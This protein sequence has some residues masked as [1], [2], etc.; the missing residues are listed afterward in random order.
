[1]LGLACDNGLLSRLR[2][3]YLKKEKPV[4][5]VI[6]SRQQ[7]SWGARSESYGSII[8]INGSVTVGRDAMITHTTKHQ[9]A[10][11][12]QFR[13]EKLLRKGNSG[14]LPNCIKFLQSQSL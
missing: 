3:T 5:F 10:V 14:L 4:G 1:M 7:S 11:L 6:P 8:P 9:C 12:R 13:F 2:A